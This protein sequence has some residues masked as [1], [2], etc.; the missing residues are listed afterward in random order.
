MAPQSS[1]ITGL[2]EALAAV[3]AGELVVYPTETF[4]ALG[5]DPFSEVAME[6]LFSLKG[7]D[8]E[9]PVALIAADAPM[10]FALARSIPGSAYA[11]AEA[12]WP[13]PLTLLL[14]PREGI[15][16]ALIGPTGAVGV[17]VSPNRVARALSAGLGCPITATSANL[18]GQPPASTLS[19]ARA[20]LGDRVRVYLEGGTLHASAPST[21]VVCEDQGLRIVRAGAIVE[22]ELIAALPAGVLK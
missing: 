12:F 15:P 13:G 7:R 2:N 1:E 14:P 19:A 10:A 18:S 6:R 11:L 16:A 8:P 17:R 5:V 20:A 9:K 21:V 4:Y 22:R 3:R